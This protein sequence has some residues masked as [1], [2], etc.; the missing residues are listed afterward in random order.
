MQSNLQCE[1]SAHRVQ[2]ILYIRQAILQREENA[3][4]KE[5]LRNHWEITSNLKKAIRV[6]EVSIRVSNNL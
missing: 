6:I 3:K 4:Y 1:K 2:C 5:E